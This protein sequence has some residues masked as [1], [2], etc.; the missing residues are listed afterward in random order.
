MSETTPNPSDDSANETELHP[1][2]ADA[3][4]DGAQTEAADDADAT[5]RTTPLREHDAEHAIDGSASTSADAGEVRADDA[6]VE[7]GPAHAAS[8]EATGAPNAMP[9][10]PSAAAPNDALREEL[11][12]AVAALQGEEEPPPPRRVKREPPPIPE[13]PGVPPEQVMK[14][15]ASVWKEATDRETP[16]FKQTLEEGVVRVDV[17]AVAGYLA[18]TT[19]TD[20]HRAIGVRRDMVAPLVAALTARTVRD[21]EQWL[22]KGPAKVPSAL[23]PAVN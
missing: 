5:V 10:P 14:A 15:L 9:R 12:A 21:V 4:S 18:V 22:T 13:I 16:T 11:E 19:E 23:K 1:A 20:S 17:D 7:R 2:D 8:S 6:G 3:S